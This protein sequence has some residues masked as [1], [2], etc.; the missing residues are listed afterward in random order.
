[1]RA[2]RS[3]TR[4]SIPDAR[5]TGAPLCSKSEAPTITAQSVGLETGNWLLSQ[6]AYLSPNCSRAPGSIMLLG[7]P[8]LMLTPGSVGMNPW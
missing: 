2:R 4:A 1:M 7:L 3:F 8:K 6:N 5:E